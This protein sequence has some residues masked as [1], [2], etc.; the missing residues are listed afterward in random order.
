MKVID[1]VAAALEGAD[2]DVENRRIVWPTGKRMTIDQTAGRIHDKI[3]ADVGVVE[4]H[5]MCWMEMHFE[6]RGLDR[7]QIETFEIKLGQWI[8]DHKRERRK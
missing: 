6:P 5:V 8:E 3:N 4:S 1:E 2:L 7:K